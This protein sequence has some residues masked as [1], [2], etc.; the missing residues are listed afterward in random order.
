[1]LRKIL[2]ALAV[3]ACGYLILC[4]AA[5]KSMDT[6]VTKQLKASPEA[7]YAYV[8]DLRLWPMWSPWAAM[9]PKTINTYSDVSNAVGSTNAWKSNHE[10]VGN[11]NQT[12]TEL[13][14]NQKVAAKM[15]FDDMPGPPS[16]A[17]MTFKAVNG[18]TEVKWSMDSTGTQ[19]LLMRGMMFAMNAKGMLEQQFGDGLAKLDSLALAAPIAA[20]VAADSTVKKK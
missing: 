16:Y 4:F 20:P 17:N 15:A 14:P 7:L 6:S 3:L 18:G 12:F 9:D 19:P 5:P 2:I 1:M 10:Y 13:I 8:S 11:G